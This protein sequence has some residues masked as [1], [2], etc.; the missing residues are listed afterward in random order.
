MESHAII[1]GIDGYDPAVGA[2]DGAV[3]DAVDFATW[4]VRAGGVPAANL[5]LLLQPDPAAPAP[6]VPAEL[7]ITSPVSSRGIR[8]TIETLRRA[9]PAEGGKRLYFYYAGH[10]A[11]ILQWQEDPF[12]IPPEF[13][14]PALDIATL[15]GFK[16]LFHHLGELA[17]EEQVCLI[18]ACRDFG[19]EGYEPVIPSGA[20]RKLTERKGR[21]YV[22]YSVAPGQKAAETG[23]G[24][25][26]R[27]LI[28]G[29]EGRDY[30]PVTR[31]TGAQSRYEV[32]LDTL[33]DWVRGEVTRRIEKK[34]LRDAA[35]FVQTPQYDRDKQG[36]DPLMTAFTRDTVPKAKLRIFVEPALSHQTCKVSVM[37][38]VDGLGEEIPIAAS[39]A[40]PLRVPVSFELRPSDYSIRA[41]ADS[42]TV[43][44]RGW[45]VFDDPLVKLTLEKMSAAP[46][47]PVTTP[48][49]AA[50]SEE[51]LGGTTGEEPPG[52]RPL[53]FGIAPPGGSASGSGTLEVLSQD[54]S[55]RIEVLDPRRRVIHQGFGGFR[56][57]GLRPGV[58]RLRTSLPDSAVREETVDVRP[59]AEVQVSAS[60]PATRL[61][62]EVLDTLRRL[63]VG[64]WEKEGRIEYLHPSEALGPI[65]GTRLA[66]LLAFAAFAAQQP[67]G[68][69]FHRLRSFGVRPLEILPGSSCGVL[70]LA[71]ADAE[72]LGECDFTLRSPDGVVL[73]QGTF[74]PLPAFGAAAQRQIALPEAGSLQAE[75]RMRGVAHTRYALVTL[76]GWLTIF[77]AV[78]QA[79]GTVEVQ[80]HLIPIPKP[81]GGQDPVRGLEGLRRL[82]LAEAF[83]TAGDL[84]AALDV[85]APD[86]E[87]LLKG[88]AS[89]PL[90]GCLAG[91]LLLEAENDTTEQFAQEALPHLL[92]SFPLLPDLHILAGLWEQD[93]NRRGGHFENAL[94][95]GLPLFA[96]G[97]RALAAC[98]PRKP[99]F[100]AEPLASLLPGSL[101][102]AWIAR[103]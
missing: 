88:K 26:T 80:Q 57:S 50:P 7:T 30:R 15:L 78:A 75:L 100:L 10:G 51:F 40:P 96:D 53:S 62:A 46:A 24:I 11:S 47:A 41:E 52:G 27:T 20:R 39:P 33:A 31:G 76:E 14:D 28:D 82:D 71:G 38:Y 77:I 99:D 103:T 90:L 3:R 45:T 13:I 48:V 59:G 93:A 98:L 65:A 74:D 60:P 1:I 21:Q 16:D 5:R 37:Q 81:S 64:I 87:D 85:I 97:L 70:A 68:P 84:D 22:L 36:G 25:W 94:R 2:L 34:F 66:S 101:W 79:D 35:R 49:P 73:N 17:F 44:S 67:E 12:L 102:T 42:F 8:S 56:L 32:R 61:G 92:R 9:L 72:L 55:L 54:S 18:D 19:L 29:L 91:Y 63:G 23:Q 95:R 89:N 58:Y 43:G 6:A 69:Y 86:V 83:A 4:A